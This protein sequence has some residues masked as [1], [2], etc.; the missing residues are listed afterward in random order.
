M[1][2]PLGLD[3][4]PELLDVYFA[5]YTRALYLAQMKDPE[6]EEMARAAAEFLGLEYEYRYTGY[7]DLTGAIAASA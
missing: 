5:N 1:K 6:L 4:H 7:G 2:Q 3:K